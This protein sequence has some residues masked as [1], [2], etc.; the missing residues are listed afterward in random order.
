MAEAVDAPAP[1]QEDGA[2][3]GGRYRIEMSLGQGGMGAVYRVRDERDGR[4]LALKLL[5][6]NAGD[7]QAL[8]FSQFEREYHTLAQ[9]AHPRII[10]VYDYD[11]EG[12]TA[13]YTMELLDGQDLREGGRRGWREVC[14]VL[15]DVASSLAIIHSRRLV[16]RDVSARNVRLTRDG[17]AKLIDFGAMAPMIVNKHVVGTPPFV[18]PEALQMQALDGRAD[19]YGLGSLAYWMLTGRHAYPARSF[20]QLRDLWR[21]P[22]AS[23]AQ[24]VPDVPEALDRLVM[25]LIQLDRAGRPSSAA[26]VME[27]LSGIAGLPLDELPQVSRAY[28][29]TP[30]LVGRDAAL[31]E[32]RRLLVQS[33]QGKGG[34]ML[35]E[36]QDGVGC[37]RFLDAVVLEAK[38]LGT[39]VLRGDAGDATSEYGVVKA[40]ARQWLHEAPQLATRTARPWRSLLSHILPELD[41]GSRSLRPPPERRHLQS[42]LRNW[43]LLAAAKKQLVIAVDDVH[44]IDE[45]SAALLG[46]LAQGVKSHKLSLIVTTK[47]GA[48]PTPALAVLRQ[49]ART[50]RLE[51]LTAAQTLLLLR[52]VFGDVEHINSLAGRIHELA[53]GHPRWTMLLCERLVERGTARYQAGSWSLPSSLSKD[54]LPVSLTALIAARVAALGQDARELGEVLSLTDETAFGP[55]EYVALTSHREPAR[56]H[57]ALDELI[58][59]GVLVADGPHYRFSQRELSEVLQ[60]GIDAPRKLELHRRIADGM[61][62]VSDPLLLAR[63]LLM[64]GREQEGVKYLCTLRGDRRLAYSTQVFGLLELT[65]SRADAIGLSPARQLELNFWLV[66]QTAMLGDYARFHKYAW[67]LLERL[68]TESGLRDYQDLEAEGVAAEARLRIALERAEQRNRALPESARG[69]SPEL[70]RDHLCMLCSVIAGMASVSMELTPIERLPS[71]LPLMPV[72]P[73]VEL[74]QLHVDTNRAMTAAR[75]D[76]AAANL[77][78]LG[79]RLQTP[80]PSLAPVYIRQLQ[81]GC[82]YMTGLLLSGIAHSATRQVLKELEHEPGHRV[83]AWRLYMI[84]ELSLGNTE[85]AAEC[86]RRA[87]L[88][89]LQDGGQ[90]IFPGTTAASELLI[91]SYAGDLIAVKRVMERIGGL[92]ER[93]PGWRPFHDVARAQYYHLQ[94]DHT[95]ALA[96]LEPALRDAAPGR[97][98]AWTLAAV[99]HVTLLTAMGATEEAITWAERYL[100]TC[101]RERLTAGHLALVRVT[102][103]ALSKAGRLEEALRMA[104]EHVSGHLTRGTKGL[105]LGLAYEMRARVAIAMKDELSLRRYA[106]LCAL[107]YKTGH[108]LTLSAKYQTLM[109]EAEVGG[110]SVTSGLQQAMA[111]GSVGGATKL[112]GRSTESR[113]LTC[114]GTEERAEE[115]MRLLLELTGASSGYLFLVRGGRLE[116][117]APLDLADDEAALR[118]ML[119]TYLGRSLIDRDEPTSHEATGAT[120]TLP[121]WTDRG[122]RDYEPLVL[123]NQRD[124]RSAVTAVAAL[125]YETDTRSV[126]RRDVLDVLAELLAETDRAMDL[127]R[128]TLE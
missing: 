57:R 28:L 69:P 26:E 54:D 31:H 81:L 97:T 36:G 60:S 23:P 104:D 111:D 58:A 115:S 2:L 63:H 84:Y 92:A 62:M 18:P 47:R 51:P 103:E 17:R 123:S 33:M 68:M 126:L 1:R 40:L 56:V 46:A 19:L 79:A 8:L 101:A 32:V 77:A 44:A 9:L 34:S 50:L 49:E 128:T 122:G 15:R 90:L 73:P 4:T 37:S 12:R 5:R 96:A 10:E 39:V 94:G 7:N 91:Y 93:Y 108:N 107:E 110:I 13:F 86:Q 109:R 53:H 67:P 55:A 66:A 64:G 116:L 112:T 127:D 11:V 95:A 38:L 113:L 70:A 16:H 85:A 106:E 24:Y 125:H 71:L 22:P 30:T 6:T 61:G 75:Y 102:A 3:I 120:G 48:P 20:D 27:R 98:Q 74:V 45:E 41:R 43:F 87:E 105:Q 119:T 121:R 88:L 52:S 114:V 21:S 118:A 76:L 82:R 78:E 59:T 99:C 42:A 14:A 124:G 89:N 29:A 100:A 117:A 25:S 80:H 65:L 35:V 83:L 72:Y